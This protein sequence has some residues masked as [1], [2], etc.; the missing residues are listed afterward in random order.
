MQRDT[1]VGAWK[2]QWSLMRPWCAEI[3]GPA[4]L[5]G[6]LFA[7]QVDEAAY[8][9][10]LYEFFRKYHERSTEEKSFDLLSLCCFDAPFDKFYSVLDAAD[11]KCEFY[12]ERRLRLNLQ[13]PRFVFCH[14]LE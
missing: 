13:G 11:W 6:M 8:V 5:F 9:R 12:F 2:Q 14:N 3:I 4:G 7:R 10:H 1:D